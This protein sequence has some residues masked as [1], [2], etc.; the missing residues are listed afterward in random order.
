MDSQIVLTRFLTV[1]FILFLVSCKETEHNIDLIFGDNGEFPYKTEKV[2]CQQNPENE[3]Y[4][5][6]YNYDKSGN[7]TGEITYRNNIPDMKTK[8]SFNSNNQPVTDSVFYFIENKWKADRY[9]KYIYS[10]NHLDEKQKYN[11]EGSFTHK[12]VYKYKGSK[13]E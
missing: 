7:L 5:K 2:F 13:P 8:S 6:T 12:T 3:I 10:N 4:L 9:F 11:A 1:L